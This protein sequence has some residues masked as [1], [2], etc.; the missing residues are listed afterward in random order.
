MNSTTPLPVVKLIDDFSAS[1]GVI[2]N[3]GTLWTFNTDLDAPRSKC[4]PRLQ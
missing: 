1:Y 3:N 4:A 2:A